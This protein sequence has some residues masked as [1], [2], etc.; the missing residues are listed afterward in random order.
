MDEAPG[1]LHER[2]GKA[3]NELIGPDGSSRPTG[4]AGSGTEGHT[5]AV[6]AHEYEQIV[7][8]DTY[9]QSAALRE[10]AAE[11]DQRHEY[12]TDLLNDVFLAAHQAQPQLREHAQMAPSRRPNHRV[13]AALLASVEF[14]E[15][16]RATVGDRYAAALAVLAQ[17]PA[18]RRLLARTRT[19]PP[20]AQQ[21]TQAQQ[22]HQNSPNTQD[23]Q[24]THDTRHARH[25][26]SAS[27]SASGQALQ[28][29]QV[30]AS[31]TA[32][33]VPGI[34]GGAWNAATAGAPAVGE[35]AA[36]LRAWGLGP[37]ELERM[38]FHERARLAQ[39]LASSRLAQWT[40]LIGRFRQ[41]AEGE[42]ARKVQNA[43]G[44]LF[45]VTLGDD[46]ARLIPSE[47]AH[48]GLP[49]M[50]AVFA[51]RYAAGELM[52]YDSQAEQ[53]TG[54]GAIIAC[55]D[56]SH[57]MLINGPG[58]VTREAWAKACALALLDQARRARR[59]FVGILFAA[60]DALQ[61]FRFPADQAADIPRVIDFTET[62]L[63][64]GTSYERPLSAALDLLAQEYD[65]TARP[66]GDIVMLTDGECDVSQKWTH[67][68]NAAKQRLGFRLFG[69]TIA[70]PPVTAA[71][72]LLKTLS[73]DHR[74]IDDLTDTH[75]AADLFR[76]I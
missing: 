12:A 26:A 14:A 36:L 72:T 58:H 39:R 34:R 30:A 9:A 52:L 15:L 1:R 55:V 61:V 63:G 6:L 28:D 68:W 46:L 44:E 70:T 56:T 31:A 75:A 11:L 8:R 38:P 59:D 27:A 51:A 5:A 33:V 3:G 62:F 24:N 65:D 17:A 66:R 53:P 69:V 60:T 19:P 41:M 10:F 20:Q 48:L 22:A 64:G 76:L 73:D 21:A 13:M 16:H 18:L 67:A 23:A 57:S 50:R 43:S 29:A 47:L 25:A 54:Q 45:D 2:A 37:G 40:Q 32:A 35:E 49:Q 74:T 42:C 4:S 71:G 7:W